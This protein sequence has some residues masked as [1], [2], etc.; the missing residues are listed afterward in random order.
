MLSTICNMSRQ[1]I[2]PDSKAKWNSLSL[3]WESDPGHPS[4]QEGILP[5]NYQGNKK[6]D[7]RLNI[8]DY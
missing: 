3:D 5:L 1:G 2:L 7:Y 6:I 8:I 4:Y